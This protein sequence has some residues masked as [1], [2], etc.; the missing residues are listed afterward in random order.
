MNHTQASCGHSVLAIGAPGS[1]ARTAV[2]TQPCADCAQCDHNEMVPTGDP[3][4]VWKCAI[5]G[6]VYGTA[7]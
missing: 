7:T 2:E 6:Y 4:F 3:A 5:C 1:A